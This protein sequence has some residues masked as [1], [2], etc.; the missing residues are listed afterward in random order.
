MGRSNKDSPFCNKIY[1]FLLFYL[2]INPQ[3]PVVICMKIHKHFLKLWIL[4]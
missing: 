1:N 2:Y 3:I 4:V